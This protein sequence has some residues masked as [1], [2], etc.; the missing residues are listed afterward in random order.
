M[1]KRY[2]IK[3]RVSGAVLGVYVADDPESAIEAMARE[4]GYADEAEAIAVTGDN[5]EDL[6]ATEII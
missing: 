2:E 6:I 5:P 1:K 4:A 3:N